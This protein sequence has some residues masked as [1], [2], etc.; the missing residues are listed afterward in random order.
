MIK[1]ILCTVFVFFSLTIVIIAQPWHEL[2]LDIPGLVLNER[3]YSLGYEYQ[4][5]KHFGLNLEFVSIDCCKELKAIP[6]IHDYR[7]EVVNLSLRKHFMSKKQ[8]HSVFGGLGVM[9]IS[10]PRYPE[11]NLSFKNPVWLRTG[12]SYSLP[13]FQ[14]GFAVSGSF[15]YKVTVKKQLLLEPSLWINRNF[16]AYSVDPIYHKERRLGLIALFFKL[17]YRFSHP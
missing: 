15:G 11:V 4:M 10:N 8:N 16:I 7:Q 17:G 14:H 12:G 6:Q 2:K 9:F 5:N 3:S 13:I 1:S